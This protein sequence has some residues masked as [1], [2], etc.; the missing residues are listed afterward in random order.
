MPPNG[1]A[2][3]GLRKVIGS[4]KRRQFM[5]TS[6]DETRPPEFKRVFIKE[7]RHWRSGKM[8]RA[9]DYGK[10]VFSFLIKK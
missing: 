9:Q 5:S 10:K 7:F 6:S 8:I 2:L 4:K 3:S 1:I